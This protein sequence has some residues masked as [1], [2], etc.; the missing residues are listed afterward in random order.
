ML[1]FP[2]L[3]LSFLISCNNKTG[4]CLRLMRPEEKEFIRKQIFPRQAH[5]SVEFPWTPPGYFLLR[6]DQCICIQDKAQ[7]L[8]SVHI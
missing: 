1:Y 6:D 2:F 8:I 5:F 7:Y 4:S 3:Y